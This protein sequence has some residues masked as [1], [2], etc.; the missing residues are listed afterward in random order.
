MATVDSRRPT[1]LR[2]ATDGTSVGTWLGIDVGGRGKGCDAALSDDRRL[3]ELATR[4][5]CKDVVDLVE[6]RKPVAVAIDSPRCCASLGQRSRDCERQLAKAIC[7]IR[8]TPEA[9]RVEADRYYEW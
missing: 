9:A 2:F 8:W 6:A 5:R 1:R 7:G 4:L 3:L